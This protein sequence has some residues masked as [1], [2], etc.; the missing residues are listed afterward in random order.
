MGSIK[1]A[2]KLCG[3]LWKCKSGMI[4][5]RFAVCRNF[6]KFIF[7]KY[8]KNRNSYIGKNADIGDNLVFPHGIRGIYI[9][10]LSKIGE[11]T[12]IFH[13][14]TI[15]SN[16]LP[17]SKNAGAPTIGK[18]CLIGAGAMIIGNVTIGDNCRIGANAIVTQDIPSNS[19]VVMNKPRIIKKDKI[20]NNCFSDW[21]EFKKKGNSNE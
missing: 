19:I 1:I 16:T 18:K 17:D 13:Q 8:L 9:S 14:V 12:I 5:S 6:Y 3:G 21:K 7:N 10:G 2:V 11:D 20:L 4:N 15:G